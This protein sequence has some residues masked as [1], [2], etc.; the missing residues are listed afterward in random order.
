MRTDYFDDL[1]AVPG[2]PDA[3]PNQW[4]GSKARHNKPD[5]AV[6]AV[7]ADNCEQLNDDRP[8]AAKL[9]ALGCAIALEVE[10]EV[11]AWI[12]ADAE[13]AKRTDLQGAVFTAQEVETLAQFDAKG[14]RD[15][16]ALKARLGG[17]LTYD[18]PTINAEKT[19]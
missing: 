15:L 14:I 19:K 13:E 18:E 10:G 9:R 12:V 1:V 3:F 17:C 4:E 2:V 11:V 7:P 8:L 5:P 6:P 16:I